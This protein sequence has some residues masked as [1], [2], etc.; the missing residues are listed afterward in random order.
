MFSRCLSLFHGTL[1]AL[2][3]SSFDDSVCQAE[4]GG[5]PTDDGNGGLDVWISVGEATLQVNPE[6]EFWNDDRLLVVHAAGCDVCLWG[7]V[8]E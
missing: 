6:A 5:F 3:T 2:S 4:E 8:C 7:G 1:T